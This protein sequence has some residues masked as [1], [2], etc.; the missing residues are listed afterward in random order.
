MLVGDAERA[1]SGPF[2]GCQAGRPGDKTSESVRQ[3]RF[4]G[5]NNEARSGKFLPGTF[6]DLPEASGMRRLI[7]WLFLVAGCSGTP[8]ELAAKHEELQSLRIE[9]KAAQ[10]KVRELP[11]LQRRRQELLDEKAALLMRK[12]KAGRN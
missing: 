11:L 9:I 4:P 3:G 6:S 8:P 7:P 12:M 10:D 2:G 5:G 1:F